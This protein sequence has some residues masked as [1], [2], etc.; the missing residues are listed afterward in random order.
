MAEKFENHKEYVAMILKL[1]LGRVEGEVEQYFDKLYR[2]FV[3]SV[4]PGDQPTE[5]NSWWGSP[6]LGQP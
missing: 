5:G 3:V 1:P 2:N 6:V 4:F